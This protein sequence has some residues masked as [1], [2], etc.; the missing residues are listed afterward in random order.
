MIQL[1]QTSYF[2]I[3]KNDSLSCLVILPD[4]ESISIVNTK[5]LNL[6][7]RNETNKKKIHC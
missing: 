2:G 3:I 4:F 1:L 6:T 7:I 5:L